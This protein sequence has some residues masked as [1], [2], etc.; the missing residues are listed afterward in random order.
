MH[1]QTR[2]GYFSVPT[3]FL[4]KRTYYWDYLNLSI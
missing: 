3:F 1:N 4:G 2:Y